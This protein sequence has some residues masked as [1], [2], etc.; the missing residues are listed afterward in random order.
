MPPGPRPDR[1]Q[2]NTAPTR[3]ASCTDYCPAVGGETTRNSHGQG[4][5]IGPSS[6]WQLELSIMTDFC[7]KSLDNYLPLALARSRLGSLSPSLVYGDVRSRSGKPSRCFLRHNS[8]V[9]PPKKSNA[10]EGGGAFSRVGGKADPCRLSVARDLGCFGL[11]LVILKVLAIDD[12]VRYLS[13]V[14]GLPVPISHFNCDCHRTTV[15]VKFTLL[16]Y[17]VHKT[18]DLCVLKRAILKRFCPKKRTVHNNGDRSTPVV[19]LLPATTKG[20]DLGES[21]SAGAASAVGHIWCFPSRQSL[22]RLHV[23][24]TSKK[25]PGR[26]N[27]DIYRGMDRVIK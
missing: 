23:T 25:P 9:F 5:I 21:R 8:G 13:A 24:K 14:H 19:A 4:E 11:S 10:R 6:D 17:R 20:V 3:P 2:T 7:R 26:G 22:S 1:D 12:G 18:F 27:V 16:A 15:L